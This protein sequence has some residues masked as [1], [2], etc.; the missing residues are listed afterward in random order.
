MLSHK[1]F[2]NSSSNAL[3]E[4]IETKYSV[5]VKIKDTQFVFLYQLRPSNRS[6]WFIQL[7]NYLN[8]HIVQH[9]SLRDCLLICSRGHTTFFLTVKAIVDLSQSKFCKRDLKYLNNVFVYIFQIQFSVLLKSGQVVIH[10]R[11][12]F[13]SLY[14][15]FN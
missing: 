1:T 12:V 3:L 11:S 13:I 14:L 8:E 10:R 9:F 15:F 5:L 6:L 2:V 7:F 4:S